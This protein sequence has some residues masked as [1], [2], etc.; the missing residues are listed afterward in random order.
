ML[1]HED[2]RD[3][4]VRRGQLAVE[5]DAAHCCVGEVVLERGLVSAFEDCPIGFE[6]LFHSLLHPVDLREHL[7]WWRRQVDGFVLTPEYVSGNDASKVALVHL[8]RL[9]V[10][11][12]D[13]ED[14]AEGVE[15][16]L[17]RLG[18]AVDG[19]QEQSC[20]GVLLGVSDG[21]PGVE[22]A[23]ERLW[24]GAEPVLEEAA[25]V[26]GALHLVVAHVVR[27]LERGADLR[28]LDCVA[29]QAEGASEG[30]AVRDN[31][32]EAALG[33]ERNPQ[34]EVGEALLVVLKQFCERGAED[35]HDP[36]SG[37]L[38]LLFS[39]RGGI[40]CL[41]G[42]L[43][44]GGGAAHDEIVLLLQPR[45]G[46]LPERVTAQA[47]FDERVHAHE[48][49]EGHGVELVAAEVQLRQLLQQGDVSRY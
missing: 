8:G 19:G 22:V 1:R 48:R 26:V 37:C 30:S 21:H 14:P 42:R 29:L 23:E 40:A 46:Q 4:L 39:S 16:R 33:K 34:G 38:Q 27:R 41:R 32:L 45:V 44:G 5:T 35:G 25:G 3:R 17:V 13:E 47:H 31:V 12:H 20:L 18:E 7:L 10:A 2:A 28:H 9:K 49:L 11:R 6:E 15:E 36:P 43:L 24:H